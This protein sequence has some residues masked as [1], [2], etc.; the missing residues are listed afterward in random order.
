MDF[1]WWYIEVGP[2]V[3]TNVSLWCE[4]LTAEEVVHVGE[5]GRVYGNSVFSTQFCY[6]PKQIFLKNR[7]LKRL[8]C[9]LRK[10]RQIIKWWHYGISNVIKKTPLHRKIPWEHRGVKEHLSWKEEKR[11]VREA[12]LCLLPAGK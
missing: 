1:R 2:S 12:Y 10:C 4:M 5:K 6:K 8:C 3:V 7:A 9:L 11:N